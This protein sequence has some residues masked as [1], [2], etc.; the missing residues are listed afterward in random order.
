[1]Q[2]DHQTE[3]CVHPGVPPSQQVRHT[4]ECPHLSAAALT[5]LVTATA[6][7]VDA[8]PACAQCQDVVNGSRR[9]TFDSFEAAMEAFQAPLENRAKMREIAAGLT[10]GEI[11]IP[12]SN[13]YIA[14][15]PRRGDA[16]LAYFNRGYVAIHRPEGGYDDVALP[17]NWLRE[18]GRSASASADD[19][20][21]EVCPHCFM[22]LPTSGV[23]GTCDD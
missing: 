22:E 6:E 17:L 18:G 14:V 10:F 11:W 7:Q 20:Q 21:R 13:P 16:V 2:I 12:A 23:C 3:W 5:E 1:M 4:R 9:R 8:L 19:E 15:A